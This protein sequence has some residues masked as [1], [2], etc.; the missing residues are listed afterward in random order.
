[1]ISPLFSIFADKTVAQRV[2]YKAPVSPPDEVISPLV[3]GKTF[4]GD[5]SLEGRAGNRLEVID[6]PV[7]MADCQKVA[8]VEEAEDLII[9]AAEVREL[10]LSND[11]PS[12]IGDN[13][14][15]VEG[16][17]LQIK[18]AANIIAARTRRG[19][20]QVALVSPAM[21]D[22]LLPLNGVEAV[23]G[24]QVGRWTEKALVF[25]SVKVYVGNSIPDDEIVIAYVGSSQLIDG[26]GG[27]IEEGDQL[28]LYLLP[29][30]S[31]ALGNVTDYISRLRIKLKTS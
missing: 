4:T 10:D 25:E 7:T 16:L 9:A 3:V 8:S 28:G 11:V 13:M 30:T 18:R 15:T 2:A 21:L 23:D 14:W 22:T 19:Y 17:P 29:N 26:P 31:E 24:E 1:M 5:A 27:V 12:F 6:Q 20:G